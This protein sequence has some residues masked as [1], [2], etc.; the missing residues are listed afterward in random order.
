MRRGKRSKPNAQ[1]WLF[2]LAVPAVTL[3]MLFSLLPYDRMVGQWPLGIKQGEVMVFQE[4]FDHRPGQHVEGKAEKMTLRPTGGDSVAVSI[5]EGEPLRARR[6]ALLLNGPTANLQLDFPENAGPE[7][8]SRLSLVAADLHALTALYAQAVADSLPVLVPKLG[9]VKLEINGGK[10]R[11]YLVQ[12]GITPDF[13]LRHA[14]VAMSLM[15]TDGAGEL[16]GRSS[17][18]DTIGA[19]GSPLRADRIDSMAAAAVGLLACAEQRG[20]LLRG[21]AGA[22]LDR[23]TGGITPLYRMD[24]G[25]AYEENGT[26]WGTV[27][28]EALTSV[29]VQREIVALAQG[30]RKDSAAWAARLVAIDS[31]AVPVLAQGRNIGL[32]QAEVNRRREAFLQR[33]FHPEPE[34]FI[35]PPVQRPAMPAIPLDPWLAQFRTQPDTLRF[36]RGKYDIDHDLVIPQG[37]A[38]VLEKGTRWFMAPGVSVVVNGEF[39]ARGTDLNPVFIRPQSDA[40]PWGAI[41]VNGTGNTRVRI[42]GMRI[43]GGSDLLANG[44]YHGGMLSFLQADVT[45][46]HCDIAEAYGAA[47]VSARRGTFRMADC[48]LANAHGAYVSLAEAEGSV[49]R[50]AF[51]LPDHADKTSDRAALVMR[52]CTM[53]VSGCA[54]EG[55][56]FTALRLARGSEVT[57]SQCN[58]AGNAVALLALDGSRAQVTG[59]SFS[60]N[61][62]VFV[63]R[64]ERIALGGA[65][66]KEEG[67]TFAGN[68]T[69]KEVDAA[70]KLESASGEGAVQYQSANPAPDQDTGR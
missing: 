28:R 41:A 69:F 67:N 16:E 31:A 68:R 18:G 52:S 60:G 54:F 32:V 17:V 26:G 30:L 56:P 48:V 7:G 11:P 1:A 35:G 27:F 23:M 38:V 9:L 20:G 70:S 24:H 10:A 5:G 50:T 39:H 3:F 13:V 8:V 57:V 37:I 14:P 58:F 22:M 21:E 44:V 2:G 25:N 12:E 53:D 43:S 36:V 40:R 55:L 29:P 63:L 64:R 6:S 46:D 61:D 4:L 19:A 65:T 15:G 42:R 62:K 66:V 49:R 51:V 47:T 45:M 34:R 33:L 59:C